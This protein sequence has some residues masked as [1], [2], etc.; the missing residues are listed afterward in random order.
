MFQMRWINVQ[1]LYPGE[2]GQTDY[3]PT[4]KAETCL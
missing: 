2:S 4:S 3:L 1:L